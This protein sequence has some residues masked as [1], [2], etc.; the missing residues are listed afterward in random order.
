MNKYRLEYYFNLS[1]K[2]IMMY[3][4][5]QLLKKIHKENNTEVVIKLGEKIIEF[6]IKLNSLQVTLL[7]CDHFASLPEE[8]KLLI[9]ESMANVHTEFLTGDL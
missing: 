5:D 2:E 6:E 4:I 3:E 7:Q 9:N 8:N 1:E